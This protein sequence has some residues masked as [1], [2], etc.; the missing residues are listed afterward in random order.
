VATTVLPAVK[1]R[2]SRR[3]RWRTFTALALVLAVV[4]VAWRIETES[5]PAIV[6]HRTLAADIRLPGSLPLLS[7]PRE[8]QAAVEVEGVGS[9]GAVGASTPV[10]IASVAKMMTAYLTL[11]EYP[12]AVGQEGFTMTVTHA[13]VGEEEQ[14]VGLDQSILPVKAGERISERQALQALLLPSANNMAAMLAAHDA[15][16]ITAFVAHM[17]AAAKALDMKSTTYTDPSGFQQNTVSTADDQLKLAAVA[18]REP[19]FAAIVDEPSAALPVAG[20]VANYNS[21]VGEDGYVGV[22]TG[23][24]AAAGGCLVFAKHV[25]IDGRTVT[26]LGVVLGQHE[27]SLIPA[28]LASARA[29]GDSAAAALRTQVLVPAGTSVLSASSTGGRRTTI[30]TSRA[31]RGIGWPGLTLPVQVNIGHLKAK[32][33]LTAGE[34]LAIVTVRGLR[35]PTTAA[36]AAHPLGRP[37]LGWRIQHLL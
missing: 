5:T 33:Q 35:A 16:G 31:L 24:D 12:L 21:L 22:K 17:N 23:S 26:I 25:A 30:V 32:T 28:A 15:G 11:Q 14:R 1:H 2:S 20:R 19:V 7:W 34:P 37:S 4:A 3:L 10:P 29:L 6:V 27:G 36:V 8:G 18:M 9:F 13:E